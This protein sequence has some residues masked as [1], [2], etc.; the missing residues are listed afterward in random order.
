[1]NIQYEMYKVLSEGKTK[2]IRLLPNDDKLV[3]LEAKDDITAGDGAKHDVIANKAK[4]ATRTTSNIFRLLKSCGFPVAFVEEI[5]ETRFLAERCA[6]LPYEV[7]VRREAH[8]SYLHRFPHLQAGNYFP[9]LKLEFFAKTSGK[10]W[11]GSSIPMDDP[12]LDLSNDPVMFYIPHWTDE[13]KEISKHT[14]FRGFLV[15]QKPFLSVPRH[16]FLLQTKSTEKD[17]V[18]M[19]KLAKRTFLVLEKAWQL[20]GRRLV[21]FKVEFG[22]NTEGVLRLADVIDNDSWRVI[23]NGIHID[24]QL[25]RDGVDLNTVTAK[26]QLVA[27]LTKNFKL[28]QQQLILWRASKSDDLKPFE[29]AITT[30]DNQRM[31]R[32]QIVTCSFHKEPV[33]A[34]IEIGRLIQEVPDS[35]VIAY[36]GRSNGAPTLSAQVSTPVITV[37][38]TW[39]EFPEDVWSSLRTPSETPIMTV[40]DPKNAVLFALQIL[41]MRNPRLYAELRIKQEEHLCNIVQC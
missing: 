2:I 29:E 11:N 17:L 21:D 13:Q 31:C 6:M 3:I 10:V 35:V 9:T 28:P 38:V 27:E 26:Y 14:G 41:A 4:L 7:V 22:K 5:D 33:R 1:M 12:F 19:G 30:Y 18:E 15:G 8:G 40:L 16:D 32:M 37:P 23:D 34:Y 24:K 36:V 25:Y 39:K 20:V